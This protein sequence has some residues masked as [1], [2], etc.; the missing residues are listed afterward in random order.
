MK[1]GLRAT[2][3]HHEAM[4]FLEHKFPSLVLQLRI[5]EYPLH[6]NKESWNT[7]EEQNTVRAKE[8]LVTGHNLLN[9]FNVYLREKKTNVLHVNG[10]DE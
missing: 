2:V 6:A 5:S 3:P 9:L 8:S 10:E 1:L 7:L 4:R